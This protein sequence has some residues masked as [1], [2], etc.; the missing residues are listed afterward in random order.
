MT[1]DVAAAAAG[2]INPGRA[3]SD[4]ASACAYCRAFSVGQPATE[5]LVCE[6]EQPCGAGRC[7][8]LPHQPTPKRAA[9]RVDSGPEAGMV[10]LIWRNRDDEQWRTACPAGGIGGKRR[11]ARPSLELIDCAG[12]ARQ[13]A[14]LVGVVN[15]LVGEQL[16]ELGHAR[17]LVEAFLAW[18]ATDD[19]LDD[20]GVVLAVYAGATRLHPVRADERD[21]LIARWLEARRRYP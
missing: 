10:H 17:G 5:D 13:E 6:C 7:G 18:A 14:A 1:R 20:G 21:K 19:G 12:C 15:R 4:P 9:G 16:A 11:Q 2:P 8:A 3:A